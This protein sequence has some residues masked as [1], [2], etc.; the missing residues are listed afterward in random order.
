[1]NPFIYITVIAD[2]ND[3]NAFSRVSEELYAKAQE[4]GVDLRNIRIDER[5][6]PKFDTVATG[7]DLAE[8]ARNSRLAN[9]ENI[10]RIFYVNT[11]PRCPKQL[12]TISKQDNAGEELV[13]VK[14]NNGVE[15]IAVNSGE[16]LSFL[17]DAIERVYAIDIP[18]YGSQFRSLHVFPDA[19]RRL[20]INDESL[21]K[22]TL[23]LPTYPTQSQVLRVDGYG[24]IKILVP[25]LTREQFLSLENNYINVTVNNITLPVC[26]KRNMFDS[27]DDSITLSLG[28]SGWHGH[29]TPL[30]LQLSIFQKSAAKKYQIYTQEVIGGTHVNIEGLQQ[31]KIA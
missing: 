30:L 26:I 28:S 20:L 29:N 24:N 14:L 17:P 6:V 15:I 25:E 12:S 2:Y 10:R 1:M 31:E 9:T 16:S 27:T 3:D 18:H 21:L 23:T 22:K 8:Q 4:A 11:A 13:Y 5:Q 19:L 7:F